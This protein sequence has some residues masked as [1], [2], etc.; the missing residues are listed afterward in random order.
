MR[1][2]ISKIYL[3][4]VVGKLKYGVIDR[5]VGFG[6]FDDDFL[7]VGR[8]F[9]PGFDREREENAVDFFV[10]AEIGFDFDLRALLD[11]LSR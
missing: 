3:E 7:F 2:R 10:I 8:A 6:F 9:A 1:K 4:A 11:A 5:D